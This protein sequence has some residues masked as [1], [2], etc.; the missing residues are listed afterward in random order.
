MIHLVKSDL[1]CT[2]LHHSCWTICDGEQ[3]LSQ[4]RHPNG[5]TSV[6]LCC[7]SARWRVV[8]LDS[9]CVRRWE[10][11]GGAAFSEGRGGGERFAF[12]GPPPKVWGLGEWFQ[13][14]LF[15]HSCSC[16]SIM[17]PPLHKTSLYRQRI[18]PQKTKTAFPSGMIYYAIELTMNALI[19]KNL[20]KMT[21]GGL[22]TMTSCLM[23]SKAAVHSPTNGL[24]VVF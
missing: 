12:D 21:D 7:R 10:G 8:P 9:G 23:L 13:Q 15:P 17:L 4:R 2:G 3:F 22:F 6:L 5:H 1:V 14:H 24:D 19:S 18:F 11:E 20:G 16:L